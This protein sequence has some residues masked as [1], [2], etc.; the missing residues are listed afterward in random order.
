MNRA[1]VFEQAA[2]AKPRQRFLAA[3]A[4]EFAAD[5]VARVIARLADRHRN[6]LLPQSDAQRQTGEAAADNR[7]GFWRRHL[8]KPLRDENVA[9]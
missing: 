5:A 8:F 2:Q 6:F 9:E 1:R 7:D 4:D 3:S